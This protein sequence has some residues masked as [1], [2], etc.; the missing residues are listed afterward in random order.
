MREA[1]ARRGNEELGR[2]CALHLYDSLCAKPFPRKAKRARAR[3]RSNA[4][5]SHT[6]ALERAILALPVAGEYYF[7]DGNCAL[8]SRFS[9]KLQSSFNFFPLEITEKGTFDLTIDNWKYNSII[10]RKDEPSLTVLIQSSRNAR[11]NVSTHARWKY[12]A[13][14]VA[15]LR[16]NPISSNLITMPRYRLLETSVNGLL[17]QFSRGR[18]GWL[19]ASN[20]RRCSSI[21]RMR[22]TTWN[23]IYAR[24]ACII[25]Y[26]VL[27]RNARVYIQVCS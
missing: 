27:L 5:P 17:I 14:P 23:V 20:H 25:R 19:E 9:S 26:A 21:F 16:G 15:T 3:A 11:E 24:L 4:S 7:Q 2:G 13:P 10:V 22:G 18:F 1:N 6:R 8:P 12:R